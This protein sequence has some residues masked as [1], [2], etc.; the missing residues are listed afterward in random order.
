MRKITKD[1]ANAWV[2]RK[3]RQIGNTMTD[4]KS[5]YLHGNLIATRHDNPLRWDFTLAGWNTVTTRERLN[6]LLSAIGAER[7]AFVQRKGQPVFVGLDW[8]ETPISSHEV[9][10]VK[11]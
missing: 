11:F 3:P 9:I 4:G 8:S 2:A 1:I 5:V 10:T 6:G 7:A